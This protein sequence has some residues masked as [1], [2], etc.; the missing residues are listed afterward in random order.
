MYGCGPSG[1]MG[2]HYHHREECIDRHDAPSAAAEWIKRLPSINA[3][4]LR[5]T[6]FGK[7]TDRD[8]WPVPTFLAVM[9]CCPLHFIE[10][11]VCSRLRFSLTTYFACVEPELDDALDHYPRSSCPEATSPPAHCSTLGCP[12]RVAG[13]TTYDGNGGARQPF[14]GLGPRTMTRQ[15]R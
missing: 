2:Q 11:F 8:G 3:S 15:V 1:F 6:V 5:S 12:H 7:P 9:D 4:R 10:A 13:Q 14:L